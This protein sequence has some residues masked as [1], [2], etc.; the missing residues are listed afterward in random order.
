MELISKK[1]LLLG[2]LLSLPLLLFTPVI[3][4]ASEADL[5]RS[6]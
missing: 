6:R 5:V 3:A 2:G 1:R 4:F